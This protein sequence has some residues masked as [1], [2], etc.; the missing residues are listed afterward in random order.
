MSKNKIVP[1]QHHSLQNIWTFHPKISPTG[2]IV[3]ILLQ[4]EIVPL[5]TSFSQVSLGKA[6]F[7]LSFSSI[8]TKTS[9]TF[10]FPPDSWL[11]GSP[12]RFVFCEWSWFIWTF[13]FKPRLIF[14]TLCKKDRS[15]NRRTPKT[16]D[17]VLNDY[18]S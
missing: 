12:N 15:G 10:G 16:W 8:Y 5:T 14:T 3:N 13:H 17:R 4:N 7:F 2:E 1:I 11:L 18:A 6:P 9:K